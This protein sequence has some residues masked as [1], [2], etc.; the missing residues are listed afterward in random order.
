MPPRPA[1][2]APGPFLKWAGG[3]AQ[4]LAAFRGLYPRQPIQRYVDPFLGGGAVFF[5][6]KE[7]LKPRRALLADANGEL[8][9]TYKAIRSDVEGVIE[10]LMRHKENHGEKYFYELRTKNPT[11]PSERAAR[12]IYL[13]K[14]CFNGLYRVNSRGIFNVPFGRYENPSI[15]DPQ[16]LRGASAALRAVT[17]RT[18]DFRKTLD[19]AGEGDF[20]YLD[21]PYQPVSSTAN[22]TSYTNQPFGQS[23]QEAL[24]ALYGRLAK[25]GC[26]MMLSNSDTR[27]VRKLYRGFDVRTVPARRNINSRGDRRGPVTEVVVLN[28]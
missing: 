12:L 7:T 5:H 9:A 6:V 25:R 2:A 18:G 10:A 15:F 19:K 4:L 8:I 13:N 17:L 22:F 3:K 20:V 27:F 23:D 14:T 11:S 24:A 28:Y 21:P 1:H 16:A 26:L